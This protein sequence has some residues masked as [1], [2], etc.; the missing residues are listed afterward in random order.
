MVLKD[1]LAAGNGEDRIRWQ[2]HL[3]EDD[4]AWVEQLRLQTEADNL[5]LQTEI[6]EAKILRKEELKKNKSKYIP[7]PDRDIPSVTPHF[8]IKLH[9]QKDGKGSLCGVLVLHE[10][11]AR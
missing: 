4:A 8:C 5:W 7:I 10:R 2:T 3:D 11:W 1:I 6:N 9:S